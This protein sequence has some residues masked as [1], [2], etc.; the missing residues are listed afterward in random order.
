MNRILKG[1]GISLSLIAIGVASAVAVISL[2]LRQ[3]EVRVPDLTGLDI[4]TVIEVTGQQGLQL[5]VDRREPSQAIPRDAVV[6]QSPPPGTGVKKGRTVRVVI[7]QGPSELLVPK[8]MGEPYRKADLLLRQAGLTILDVAR[9][10]SDTVERDVVM[11]QDP[12]AGSPLEKGGGVCI[13]VSLGR[14]G[15]LSITPA[16]TG[17]TAEEAVRFVDRLGLQYRVISRASGTVPPSG[18]RSVVGQ[19]PKAGYPLAAD[20]VVELYMSR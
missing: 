10:W 16:L 17:R 18:D 9:V 14:K 2:L 15:R 19:K 7:S 12:P 5:K 11:A 13:L 4:V 1:I 8:L 20:G 6:S 3:E